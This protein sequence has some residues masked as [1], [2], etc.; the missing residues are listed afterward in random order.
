M[1]RLYIGGCLFSAIVHAPLLKE[2]EY[3][4]FALSTFFWPV[5]LV[6]WVAYIRYVAWSTYKHN[7]MVETKSGC[8]MD[9]PENNS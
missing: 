1:K 3:V 6:V 2:K 4:A 7:Q 9:I 8:Y 5:P